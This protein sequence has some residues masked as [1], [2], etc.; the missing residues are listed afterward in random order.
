MFSVRIRDEEAKPVVCAPGY[1]PRAAANPYDATRSILRA[2]PRRVYYCLQLRRLGAAGPAPA[3]LPQYCAPTMRRLKSAWS[4]KQLPN[5]EKNSESVA[6]MFD[7]ASGHGLILGTG[8]EIVDT[9][10][11]LQVL[12]RKFSHRR[13]NFIIIS[14]FW[15]G[16]D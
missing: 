8:Q 7:Y 9:G 15:R 4:R 1:Q 10:F 13:L 3:P 5:F 11:F 12:R 6:S 2:A 16:W 14:V